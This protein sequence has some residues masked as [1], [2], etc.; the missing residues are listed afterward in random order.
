MRAIISST[1]DPASVAIRE[2]LLKRGWE[3]VPS[4]PMDYLVRGDMAL[5]T[6]TEPMIYAELLDREVR[7]SGVEADLLIFA[8]R[9][10]SASK[11]RCL[12][13][14]PVGNP[15]IE[16]RYGGLPRTV[17]PS[18]P[19]HMTGALRALKVAARGLPYRVSSEV[20]HHGPYLETPA[21][22]IEIGSTREEWEDPRAAEAIAR[23][24]ME[25][26]PAEGATCLGLGGGHYAPRFTDLAV[27]KDKLFGHII[28]SYSIKEV[29][30]D[31]LDQILELEP[32]LEE[33][34][35]YKPNV[36]K[37]FLDPMIDYLKDKGKRIIW[38]K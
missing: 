29:G 28:P 14:H 35:V 25:Y 8:S 21:F 15:G 36:R 27:K 30:T 17:S 26:A 38:E 24:I 7:D 34:F 20:T 12:T 6:I 3:R 9:H 32:S 19:G 18:A 5:F 37:K 13:V 31:I 33:V 22:F 1:E 2:R 10:E 4:D 23:T 11:L 16:A